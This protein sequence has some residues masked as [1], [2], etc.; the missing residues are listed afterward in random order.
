METCLARIQL[1]EEAISAECWFALTLYYLASTAE[2]R[3]IAHL[4]GVSTSFVCIC[5]KK[6]FRGH[7][8]KVVRGSKL[9]PGWWSHPSNRQ[10]WGKMGDTNVCQGLLSPLKNVKL[11]TLTEKYSIALLCKLLWIVSIASEMWWLDGQG[12]CMMPVYCSIHPFTSRV[13]QTIFFHGCR[14]NKSETRTYLLFLLEIQ[15][16]LYYLG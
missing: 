7:K 3:T 10:I 8:L 15:L 16:I 5:V 14:Q 6:G 13:M 9:S 11:T 1:C 4:F 12:V 2:F